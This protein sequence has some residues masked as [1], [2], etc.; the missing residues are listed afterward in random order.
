MFIGFFDNGDEW[1]SFSQFVS[2]DS[3]ML[4]M[5]LTI[6]ERSYHYILSKVEYLPTYI[7]KEKLDLFC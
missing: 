2:S 6:F 1:N 3:V 7:P 5:K 4:M